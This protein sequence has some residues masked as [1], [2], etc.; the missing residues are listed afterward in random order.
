MSDLPASQKH[1]LQAWAEEASSMGWLPSDTPANLDD[2][3]SSN[4]GQLFDMQDRPLVA[5]LFGGTGVGKSSLMNRFAGDSIA[6]ASAERPTSRD[7]TV[8]VHRSISVDSL[9]ETLPLER[10][11]TS[12]HTNDDYRNIMFIDMPDFD[13]VETANRE[14]VDLWLPHLDVILYVVSPERYRDDEG[15]RLLSQHA[16]EHAWL[17]IINQWDRGDASQRADFTDQLKLQGVVDPVV[18]C[19]DCSDPNHAPACDVAIASDD[20]GE[21]RNT[22]LQLSEQR[23]VHSLQAIGVV[24]RIQNLKSISD[25]W[26]EPLGDSER[27]NG[28]EQDW[29][30]HNTQRLPQLTQSLLWPV[31]QTAMQFADHTPFWRRLLGFGK[32]PITSAPV[33]LDALTQPLHE[34]LELSRDE[35]INKQ[36]HERKIPLP[37]LRA[38]LNKPDALSASSNDE[39]LIQ[40]TLYHSLSHPGTRWHLLIHKACTRLC[41]LL[42]LAAL[43]WISFRIISGFATGGANANA[44]LGS[45][46]AVNAALLLGISW[47]LPALAST[48]LRPAPEK[49]AERGLLTAIEQVT[50]QHQQRVSEAF[51]AVARQSAA[52]HAQ[53]ASL[54]TELPQNLNSPLPDSVQRLLVQ[55]IAQAPERRLDVRANTHSSTDA[56][57]LS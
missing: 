43:G 6:R 30:K 20:F 13:S 33:S 48:A 26:L 47:L 24:S 25:Q 29:Q 51:D 55:Q 10:M 2:A 37:V 53:Y 39:A 46:F 45:D 5:G 11:R 17:F 4:P 12:L 23:I 19:T 3:V 21:I 7:I 28:L 27:Y 1:R 42:P 38:A 8:Y 52:L 22:L 16:S 9:P 57:P 32:N 40:N 14:L 54:W 36:A 44:Y 50:A 31:K 34:Q 56:A 35:F 18:Y 49:A 15:W 41:L